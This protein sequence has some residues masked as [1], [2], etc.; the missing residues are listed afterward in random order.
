MQKRL[1]SLVLALILVLS[2]A[3]PARAASGYSDVPGGH[4]ASADVDRATQLG[5]FNGVG[6]GRFGL[7]QPISRAAFVTA[8]VRVFGWESVSPAQASF[9]DVKPDSWYYAAVETARA[10]GAIPAASRTF[11]PNEDITRQE[12][13]SMIVR[14]LGYTSLAGSL[15]TYSSPFSDVKASK[16]FITIAY[17]LGIVNGVGSGRFAPASTA[18]REQAAAMLVRLYDKLHGASL[19]VTSTNGLMPVRVDAP[20]ATETTEIPTTPLEPMLE[21]YLALQK[22]KNSGADMDSAVLCLT[23]GGIRTL[24]DKTGKLLGSDT[25]TAS[26]VTGMLRSASAR[27]YY[28]DRYDSAYCIY[29]PNGYQTATVWYQSE[30]SRSAKLQLARLFGVTHYLME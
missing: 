6:G 24:T 19:Q 28:S 1:F 11:R 18:T 15:S 3:L 14:S 20:A 4:W 9:S 25:L 27:L 21:L 13:A 10:N 12:M 7:G 22:L 8:L 17:D 23:A 2:P 5:I 16:G 26:E 30:R 29:T